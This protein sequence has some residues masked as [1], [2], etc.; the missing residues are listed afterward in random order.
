MWK[1]VVIQATQRGPGSDLPFSPAH[2][3]Q[4]AETKGG[5]ARVSYVTP[6]C[7]SVACSTPSTSTTEGHWGTMVSWG[8]YWEQKPWWA[9]PHAQPLPCPPCPP[10]LHSGSRGHVATASRQLCSLRTVLSSKEKR[11]KSK[12][13]LVT[14]KWPV[15]SIRL[16]I[17]KV[18]WMDSGNGAGYQ[19][20]CLGKGGSVPAAAH[21]ARAEPSASGVAP[22]AH[23]CKPGEST[24]VSW[25]PKWST[26]QGPTCPTLSPDTLTLS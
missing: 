11:S 19:C 8:W 5:A 15:S 14:L 9:S 24:S 20:P 4:L 18:G 2:N 16:T 26:A 23:P 21:C 13:V 17:C 6:P 1:T 7:G 12:V 22:P 10:W 3:G 25:G